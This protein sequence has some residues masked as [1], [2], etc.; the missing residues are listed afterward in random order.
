MHNALLYEAQKAVIQE[1]LRKAS[2]PRPQRIAEHPRSRRRVGRRRRVVALIGLVAAFGAAMGALASSALAA[3]PSNCSQSQDTVTCAFA[4]TGAEQRFTVP[5]GVSS[6][7]VDATGAAGGSGGASGSGGLGGTASAPISVTP[8]RSCT[9]RSEGSEPR[10]VGGTV[11]VTERRALE[12]AVAAPQM[13]AP[14][15]ANPAAPAPTSR[16]PTDSSSRPVEAVMESPAL[17]C[18]QAPVGQREVPGATH[19]TAAAAAERQERRPAAAPVEREGSATL[20]RQRPV[21]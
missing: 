3:L 11:A 4:F 6:V 20:E 7:H 15:P 16:S 17:T 19:R 9:S 5:S 2:L 14:S 21:D 12:V 13:C 10:P 8:G 1:R 18:S